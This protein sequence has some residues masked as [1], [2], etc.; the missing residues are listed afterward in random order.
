MISKT[1][2]YDPRFERAQT[3]AGAK[4][5]YVELDD[6]LLADLESDVERLL[7]TTEQER[8]C[9]TTWPRSDG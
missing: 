4:A 8:K 5:R 9:G 2:D 7:T 6:Y 3:I 1:S